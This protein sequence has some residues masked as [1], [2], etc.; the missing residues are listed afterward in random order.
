MWTPSNPVY[1]TPIYKRDSRYD[2]PLETEI[3]QNTKK[4]EVLRLVFSAR[5]SMNHFKIIINMYLV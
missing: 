4:K 5:P 3:G 1:S 2:F